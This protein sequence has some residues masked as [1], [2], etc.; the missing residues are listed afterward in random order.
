MG[1]VSERHLRALE[2]VRS[3]LL[4][5]RGLVE[6]GYSRRQVSLSNLLETAIELLYAH[7]FGG[8]RIP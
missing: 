5:R 6:R 4:Y 8:R 1:P 2:D 7:V 3:E